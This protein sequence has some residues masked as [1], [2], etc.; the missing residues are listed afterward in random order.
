MSPSEMNWM[1]AP[2]SRISL[3]RSVWRGR[4]RMQTVTSEMLDRLTRAMRRRFSATPALMS[5]TSAQSGPT[6][7]FS[8]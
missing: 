1:R 6:A 2:Q 3:T 8:M 4:S 5:M 7:S